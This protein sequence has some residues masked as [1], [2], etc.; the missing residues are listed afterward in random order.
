M[1]YKNFYSFKTY[2]TPEQLQKGVTVAR[3]VLERV[4]AINK[5][6]HQFYFEFEIDKK[7]VSE[8]AE[9]RQDSNKRNSS[10]INQSKKVFQMKVAMKTFFSSNPNNTEQDVNFKSSLNKLRDKMDKDKNRPDSSSH[11]KNTSPETGRKNSDK[12]S[13]FNAADHNLSVVAPFIPS[14]SQFLNSSLI[15]NPEEPFKKPPERENTTYLRESLKPIDD[16]SFYDSVS[17]F[18]GEGIDANMINFYN[19]FDMGSRI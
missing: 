10:M 16:A 7:V 8:L 3:P 19:N 4:A 17:N 5:H 9:L 13:R 14:L 6:L 2:S 1:A 18:G 15:V 12:A 11:S